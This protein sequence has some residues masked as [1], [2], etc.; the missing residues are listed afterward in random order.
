MNI[1]LLNQTLGVIKAFPDRWNQ[2]E[3]AV[4]EEDRVEYED[5]E[6]GCGTS[7]CFAGWATVLSPDWDVDERTISAVSLVEGDRIGIAT[8]ARL[9]L[10]VDEYTA[11]RLFRAGNNLT[12][13]ERIVA[14]LT[15]HGVSGD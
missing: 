8:A 12:E 1:G 10:D 11:E 2:S 7:Y 15:E 5:E 4:T 14:E 9:A 13:L 6:P 3:W